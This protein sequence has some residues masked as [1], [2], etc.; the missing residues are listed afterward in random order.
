MTNQNKKPGVQSGTLFTCCLL[1]AVMFFSSAAHALDPN[2]AAGP[3][4]WSQGQADKRLNAVSTHVCVLT[5]VAGDFAGSAEEVKIYQSNGYWYLGGK[6]RQTGISGQAYCFA[7]D[8]FLANGPERRASGDNFAIY[9]SNTP[10]NC[11]HARVPTWWGD[12]TT[13]VNGISGVLEHPATEVY[14]DQSYDP[15]APSFFNVVACRGAYASF[16]KGYGHAFFVGTYSSGKRARYWLG[17]EYSVDSS[18]GTC[19]YNTPW[20][21]G[22]AVDEV[23]MVPTDKAMCHFTAI[24][25]GGTDTYGGR[26]E[27]GGENVSIFPRMI[28][29]TEWWVLRA[30]SGY[31]GSE[32]ATMAK[33]RC[34]MRDQR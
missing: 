17:L 28:N 8:K 23:A 9:A 12:A 27:G 3:Y 5:Y 30:R 25:S 26:W 22:S 20:L 16:L 2:W 13:I 14:V 34:Y 4:S 7:K 15:F 6:S 29:G 33:A 32:R 19:I 11:T 24:G 31:C 21:T 18:E 10:T 1:S